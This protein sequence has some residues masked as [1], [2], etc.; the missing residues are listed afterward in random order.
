MALGM[1]MSVSPQLSPRLKYLKCY[2]M[3]SHERLYKHPTDFGDPLTL[4]PQSDQIISLCPVL[5]FM[6]R[7]L[8][9]LMTFQFASSVLLIKTH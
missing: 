7:Y 3:D 9:K 4:A 8:A 5:W 2:F 6:A 1:A